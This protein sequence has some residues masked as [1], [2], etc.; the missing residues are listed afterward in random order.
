LQVAVAFTLLYVPAVGLA[1]V[2]AP[3]QVMPVATLAVPQRTTGGVIDTPTVPVVGTFAQVRAAAATMELLDVGAELELLN[4]LLLLLLETGHEE[5]GVPP[6]AVQVL[7]EVSAQFTPIR[8]FTLLDK[9]L[10]EMILLLLLRALELLDKIILLLNLLELLD[11]TMLLL[12]LL[13]TG[14]EETLVP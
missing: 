2:G 14:Q 1:Q 8:Q 3:V 12:L 10:D 13:E 4:G 6:S 7:W 9:L 5:I 11:E